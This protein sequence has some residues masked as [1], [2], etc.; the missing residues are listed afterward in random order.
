MSDVLFELL[1]IFN[2]CAIGFL[3]YATIH[4]PRVRSGRLIL[5]SCALIDGRIGDMVASG[6][7]SS[8]II[9]PKF[10]LRELQVLADGKNMYKRSR[11][12]YGLEI[13]EKLQAD[14]SNK[15]IVDDSIKRIDKTDDLLIDLAK[16]LHARLCTTDYNL[17]KVAAVEG[18]D[19]L[20]LNGL[21]LA[22]R[23]NVLPGEEKQLKIIQVGDNAKQGIG[24][25]EDGAMVVVYGAEKLVSTTQ[26]V[27]IERS[28]Q[29]VSGKMCFAHLKSADAS[30]RRTPVKKRN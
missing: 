24:Y 27:V 6:F 23:T 17:G 18:V 22:L 9:I 4:K 14:Q 1:P 11:A 10:V 3:L 5:D 26:T 25:L 28:L 8:E 16:A 15:V 20:N 29:T 7:I 19:V 30:A 12:R 21:S 13:A 2:S